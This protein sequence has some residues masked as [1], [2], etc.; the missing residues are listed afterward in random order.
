M[1]AYIKYIYYICKI[2]IIKYVKMK[3]IFTQT[4]CKKLDTG[5]VVSFDYKNEVPRI[6]VDSEKCNIN[7]LYLQRY[8]R[9]IKQN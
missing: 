2:L 5:V 7:P 1:L 8:A 9:H 4:Q 6:I 3:Q